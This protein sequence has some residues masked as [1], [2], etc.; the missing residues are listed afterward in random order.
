MTK[1]RRDGETEG[2][3]LRQPLG[4]QA[5]RLDVAGARRPGSSPRPRPR[6]DPRR[7]WAWFSSG[8]AGATR[9]SYTRPCNTQQADPAGARRI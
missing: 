4:V 2:L 5:S 1:G 9:P 7:G 8:T 3:H 6:S